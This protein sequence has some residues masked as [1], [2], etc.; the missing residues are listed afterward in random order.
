M[1]KK[2]KLIKKINQI[3]SEVYF[4]LNTL[5]PNVVLKG[6]NFT[7]ILSSLISHYNSSIDCKKLGVTFL[8]FFTNCSFIEEHNK[9]IVYDYPLVCYNLTENDER[10]HRISTWALTK[11]KKQIIIKE[12]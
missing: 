6:E 7:Y 8:E 11:F 1:S 5:Y 12:K 9:I 10:G 3:R 4:E 2:K